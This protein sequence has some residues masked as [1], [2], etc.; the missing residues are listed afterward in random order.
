MAAP[1]ASRTPVSAIRRSEPDSLPLERSQRRGLHH[2]HAD[3]G[4]GDPARPA[5]PRPHGLRA[6]RHRLV[7]LKS[8][9]V[10]VL[11]EADRMLDMGFIQPIRRIVAALPRQRQNL[12]FSATMPQDIRGLAM[13]ILRDPAYVAVAPVSSTVESIYQRV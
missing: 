2:A 11:D 10:L 7:S 3:P 8:I 13:Q 12:M 5:G 4:A 9:E 1:A 6:D